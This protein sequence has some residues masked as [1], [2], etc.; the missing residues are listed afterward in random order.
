[1]DP[2]SVFPHRMVTEVVPEENMPPASFTSTKESSTPH[3]ATTPELVQSDTPAIDPRSMKKG[4]LKQRLMKRVKGQEER[5]QEEG[6]TGENEK[7]PPLRQGFAS[8]GEEEIKYKLPREHESDVTATAVPS[9]MNDRPENVT[10]SPSSSKTL[11]ELFPLPKLK[12]IDSL[13]MNIPAFV[14]VAVLLSV[15]AFFI[16]RLTATA[17]KSAQASEEVAASPAPIVPLSSPTAMIVQSPDEIIT[18]EHA[19]ITQAQE[20]AKNPTDENKKTISSIILTTLNSLTQGIA[21]YP[22]VA[23]LYYERAQVAK[24]VM[25][26]SDQL[27]NQALTDYQK[28][29]VLSPLSADY[30]AGFADYYQG[31]SDTQDSITNYQKAVQLDPKNADDLYALAKL[32]ASGDMK[33][34]ADT[35]YAKLLTLIPQASSTYATIQKEKSDLEQS[36]GLS[37]PIATSSGIKQ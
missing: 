21:S 17:G 34:D 12:P 7:E 18:K 36:M 2:Q 1:M 25:Q 26:N 11:G 9:W 27:K 29:I 8:Q 28:A 32:E 22:D 4:E 31:I 19:D 14:T 13:V 16:G 15:G 33:A 37:S 3:H 35:L 30:Y 23:A 5:V 10:P 24:L 20:L 6:R